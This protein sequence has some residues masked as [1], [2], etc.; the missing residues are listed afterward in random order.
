MSSLA[1]T[2]KVGEALEKG[3]SI[4]SRLGVD[5]PSNPSSKE[6]S[7]HIQQTQSMIRGKSEDDLLNYRLMN[8]TK[9]V[10]AMKFLA[11]LQSI[12]FL[13]KPDIHHILIMKMVQIT[14]S[15]GM[16]CAGTQGCILILLANNMS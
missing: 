13:V 10:S 12:S 1:Y 8:D 14:I 2:S 16:L 15:Y 5:V 4:V 3:L 11:A 6:L 9:M 7:E